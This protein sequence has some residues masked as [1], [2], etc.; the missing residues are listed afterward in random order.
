MVGIGE[1]DLI[2]LGK[3]GENRGSNFIENQYNISI[4][5]LITIPP[6]I[7]ASRV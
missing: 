7:S 4:F 6:S 3:H 1:E 5:S 2:S